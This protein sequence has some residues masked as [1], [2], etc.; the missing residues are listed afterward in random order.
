MFAAELKNAGVKP[1]DRVLDIGT[2]TGANLR[3]LRDLGF[4]TVTGLD[5]SEEA[6]GYCASKGLRRRCARAT[7]APCL[8]RTAALTSCWPPT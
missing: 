2:G 7:Y 5:A 8:L 4:T 3:L 6:I 1:T